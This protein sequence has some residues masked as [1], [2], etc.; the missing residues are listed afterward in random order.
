MEFGIGNKDDLAGILELLKQ[1]IENAGSSD[2]ID[3]KYANK[4][5]E[6]IENNN[7]KYFL[8]KDNGRIIGSCYICII[9]NLTYNGKSIGYIENVIV[10]KNYRKRGIGKKIMEMA[11]EYAKEN[12]CYKVVLQSG[13][14]R[15]EAH[16]FYEK[17]G[18]NGKSKKAYELR[19]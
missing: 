19:F 16:K 3:L 11:I 5:W 4:K 15:V 7:I 14:K 9:P 12:N 13:K 2:N 8:A 1:L 10:D 18:F 6:E 17:I